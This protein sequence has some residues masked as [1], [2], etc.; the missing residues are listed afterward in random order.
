LK[1]RGDN[2]DDTEG[3]ILDKVFLCSNLD[4]IAN[5]N[6]APKIAGSFNNWKCTTMMKIDKFY[7]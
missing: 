6:T 3:K 5:D 1:Q 4:I 7:D 2:K